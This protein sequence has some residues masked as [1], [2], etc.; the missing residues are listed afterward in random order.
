MTPGTVLV[1]LPGGEVAPLAEVVRRLE[2]LPLDALDPVPEDADEAT[3]RIAVGAR[4]RAVRIGRGLTQAQ[5]AAPGLTKAFVSAV[6]LGMSFPSLPTLRTLARR[7][8]VPMGVLAGD[9]PEA[10]DGPD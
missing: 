1:V 6:E 2:A 3:Y 7:L 10:G 5:L 4:I 9:G 8:N